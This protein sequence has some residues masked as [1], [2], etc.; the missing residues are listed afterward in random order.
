[1][2]LSLCLL[3]PLLFITVIQSQLLQRPLDKTRKGKRINFIYIPNCVLL[4]LEGRREALEFIER[5][6]LIIRS[7]VKNLKHK[8]VGVKGF[9]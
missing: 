3:F 4:G 2:L 6:A 1:M 8:K 7:L 5:K 9:N